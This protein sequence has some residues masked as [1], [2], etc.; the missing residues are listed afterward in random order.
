MS[1]A[2]PEPFTDLV[3]NAVILGELDLLGDANAISNELCSPRYLRA[4]IHE[5]THHTTFDSVVGLA[6]AA[7]VSSCT[8]PPGI[9]RPPEGRLAIRD[10]IVARTHYYFL[11]PLIE[12]LAV[13]AEHDL[14]SRSSPV[15]SRTSTVIANMLFRN[16]VARE[17]LAART[18]MAFEYYS[19]HL[20]EVRWNSEWFLAKQQLLSQ[21]APA[22]P[23][24]I[25]Y[26][27]VK[28]IHRTLMAR[29]ARLFDPELFL[30][31]MVDYFF[32]DLQHADLLAEHNVEAT[33]ATIGVDI[34]RLGTYV[35][36]R[37]EFLY[38]NTEQ[39]ATA[40]E[41]HYL[42][43]SIF[44]LN[45]LDDPSSTHP[46]YHNHSPELAARVDMFLLARTIHLKT[47]VFKYRSDFRFSSQDVTITIKDGSA[48]VRTAGGAE[49][50]IESLPLLPPGIYQGAVEG[51]VSGSSGDLFAIVVDRERLIACKNLATGRWNQTDT[52]THFDGFPA[53]KEQLK[54]TSALLQTQEIAAKNPS[55]APMI[56]LYEQQA[57]D[58]AAFSYSQLILRKR[59]AECLHVLA[60]LNSD[61]FKGIL[62]PDELADL[63]Q[64]SILCGCG[65]WDVTP[66]AE[67]Q[68]QAPQAI[69]ARIAALNNKLDRT[70][71]IQPFTIL[72]TKIG[73]L[74]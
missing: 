3:S 71:G 7:L 44:G 5:K 9:L 2:Q 59:G 46:P 34:A 68:G 37:M 38:A 67:T 39:L 69:V 53:V 62:A 50:E 55:L 42:G 40:C 8:M 17:S 35:Q 23:Y 22:S 16:R 12:G 19:N 56:M 74:F 29:S 21:P 30:T 64:W 27:A 20:R 58:M 26:L 57:R 51:V 10:L 1:Q 41:D 36:D 24:L 61:G 14:V 52:V 49:K 32:N 33:P 28:S 43:R 72:G 66:F 6:F 25:G 63:A 47:S 48:I 60:P 31:L 13:F 54:L 65:G 70:L 73:C 45:R 4:L 11:Q 18:E 15:C